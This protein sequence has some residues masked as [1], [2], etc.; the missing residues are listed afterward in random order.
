MLPTALGAFCPRHGE[1]VRFVADM[2]QQ[3]EGIGLRCHG[4]LAARR[5]E[6]LKP[7]F[8]V[9]ALGDSKHQ[10]VFDLKFA[11]HPPGSPKLA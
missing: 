4:H 5:E 7:G 11:K 2:L 9:S 3:V 1:A 8:S 6:S 10:H